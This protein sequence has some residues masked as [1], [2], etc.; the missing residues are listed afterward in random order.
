MFFLEDDLDPN[1]GMHCDWLQ[2]ILRVY[3][4]LVTPSGHYGCVFNMLSVPDHLF[5]S[6]LCRWFGFVNIAVVE[7]SFTMKETSC[8]NSCSEQGINVP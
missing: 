1:N 6:W 8:Y 5:L 7:A 2:E 3:L 4:S